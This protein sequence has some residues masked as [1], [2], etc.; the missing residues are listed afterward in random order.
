MKEN[1]W[2]AALDAVQ[3]MYVCVRALPQKK[4]AHAKSERISNPIECNQPKSN[5]NSDILPRQRKTKIFS[6]RKSNVQCTK[7]NEYPV[8]QKERTSV[9]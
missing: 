7:E 4:H 2:V 5:I 8:T 1:Y 6:Q 3:Q 9:Q